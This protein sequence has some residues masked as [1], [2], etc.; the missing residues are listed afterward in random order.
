MKKCNECGRPL[1]QDEYDLCPA[2]QSSKSHKKKRWTEIIGGAVVIVVG[3]AIKILKGGKAG[4][5]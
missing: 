2:C 1:N 5:A 4:K 3:I